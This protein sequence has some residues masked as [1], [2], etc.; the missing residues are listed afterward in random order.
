[1]VNADEEDLA[2]FWKEVFRQYDDDGS[3]ELD[4]EEFT[5]AM[6]RDAEIPKHK[7]PTR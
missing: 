5:D 6:R 1:M 3:G 7:V 2:A 4:I